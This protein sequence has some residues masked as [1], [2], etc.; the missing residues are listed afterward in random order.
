MLIFSLIYHGLV[1]ACNASPV[2]Y[3]LQ[4]RNNLPSAI[5]FATDDDIIPDVNLDSAQ[6]VLGIIENFVS[7]I[8]DQ[9]QTETFINLED[10]NSQIDDCIDCLGDGHLLGRSVDGIGDGNLL[11]RSIG[12]K[13]RSV[14]GLGGGNLLGRSVD[15]LG[16]GNLLGRSID[17]LGGGNFLSRSIDGLGGGNLLGRSL[18]G[19]GG[20]YLLKRSSSSLRQENLDGLGGGNLLKR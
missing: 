4:D 17:G 2:R 14:D 10:L 3:Q 1:I 13:G 9:D 20:G 7:D 6:P 11:K 12:D 15:G 18:D 19:L 8:E 5:V 16:G